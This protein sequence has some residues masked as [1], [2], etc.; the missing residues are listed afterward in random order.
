M[1][2]REK[3]K[4]I[5]VSRRKLLV[6]AAAGGGL[7]VAWTLWPRSYASPM[8]AGEGEAVFGGW[9]TIGRDGVVTIAV[10]QLEM[11][12]GVG[13]VLAQVAATELGADWRQIGIEPT[14]PAGHFPNLPLAAEWAPLWSSFPSL[15]NERDDWLTERFAHRRDF[16]A[17]ALGTSLAAYEL[18]L[19]EA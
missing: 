10:P 4:D 5:E 19:R 3:L 6:G 8:R 15:A 14:P 18:P 16:N 9:L 12:Q 7:L 1:D 13:T 11:G 2:L 17:T